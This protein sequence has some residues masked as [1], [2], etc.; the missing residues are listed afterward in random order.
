MVFQIKTLEKF[1]L[2]KA[3]GRVTQGCGVRVGYINKVCKILEGGMGGGREE[4]MLTANIL[5]G[6]AKLQKKSQYL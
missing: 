6:N 1:G 2:H 5:E 4:E 3:L